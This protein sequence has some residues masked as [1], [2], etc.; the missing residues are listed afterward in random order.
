MKLKKQIA[1]K[2]VKIR[3]RHGRGAGLVSDVRGI[4]YGLL[5]GGLFMDLINRYIDIQIPIWVLVVVTFS[6]EIIYYFLGL[7]DEKIGFWKVELDYSPRK[8]NPWSIELMKRV[9]NIENKIKQIYD[10]KNREG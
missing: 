8:L 7:I 10:Q 1:R 2:I 3:T 9:K 6:L 5:T 4:F